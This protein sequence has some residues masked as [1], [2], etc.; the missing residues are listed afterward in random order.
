MLIQHISHKVLGVKGE[1]MMATIGLL[2]FVVQ[3]LT[4]HLYM[5][6]LGVKPGG[7][8]DVVLTDVV[9]NTTAHAVNTVF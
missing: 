7:I 9:P 8:T 1:V 4:P 3:S 5:V 6:Q 2:D